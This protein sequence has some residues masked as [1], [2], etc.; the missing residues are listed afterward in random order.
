MRLY[1]KETLLIKTRGYIRL[2]YKRLVED[3][4]MK[5]FSNNIITKDRIRKILGENSGHRLKYRHDKQY[6]KNNDHVVR[7]DDNINDDDEV[8]VAV[9]VDDH[10]APAIK[11]KHEVQQQQQQQQRQRQQQAEDE[12]RENATALDEILKHNED[13]DEDRNRDHDDVLNEINQ[14]QTEDEA[15][16]NE[17][18]LE[19]MLNQEE[20]I[21]EDGEAGV[22]EEEEEEA[23][24]VVEEE[25]AV[26]VEEEAVVLN[27]A[28]EQQDDEANRNN[29]EKNVAILLL[30]LYHGTRQ[31]YQVTYNPYAMEASNL[32]FN[33]NPNI[34]SRM[35]QRGNVCQHSI[36]D[37]SSTSNLQSQDYYEILGVPKTA[38]EVII[39]K[40]YRKLAMQWHPDKNNTGAG[41]AD[42]ATRNFQIIS[43]AY[44]I[45]S[46]PQQRT[47]YD[48][49]G[50][51]AAESTDPMSSEEE[52]EE[53]D[54]EDDE[55]E[56][57]PYYR[58]FKRTASKLD[59]DK[60]SA[61]LRDFYCTFPE[62]R[63]PLQDHFHLLEE[64]NLNDLKYKF[65][66]SIIEALK[67]SSEFIKWIVP[68]IA[69][70][71]EERI[72]QEEENSFSRGLKREAQD[73]IM[74]VDDENDGYNTDNT[75][76]GDAA[77]AT[78]R[79]TKSQRHKRTARE[80]QNRKQIEELRELLVLGGVRMPT[81]TKSAV[82]T[83]TAQYIRRLQQ[84]P[85]QCGVVGTD[86][87]S[88]NK[89]R[90]ISGTTERRP[91]RFCEANIDNDNYPDNDDDDSIECIKAYDDVHN[92]S[93]NFDWV[94]NYSLPFAAID[95]LPVTSHPP[96]AGNDNKTYY[97]GIVSAEGFLSTKSELLVQGYIDYR[98]V[99]DH[100][101]MKK[102][103]VQSAISKWKR[104]VREKAVESGQTDLATVDYA[105][106]RPAEET[107]N[108]TDDEFLR[109][110]ELTIS[111]SSRTKRKRQNKRTTM[112]RKHVKKKRK[113]PPVVVPTT[114]SDTV[115]KG[116][117][118][119][120]NYQIRR[121][122]N[123]G[124]YYIG[125][126]VTSIAP[127]HTDDNVLVRTVAY[128]DGDVD[129]VDEKQLREWKYTTVNDDDHDDADSS[130]DDDD[131]VAEGNR[132]KAGAASIIDS[133]QDK[134]HTIRIDNRKKESKQTKIRHKSSRVRRRP[135]RFRDDDN[136][137]DKSNTI[138]HQ[139][140]SSR[141]RRRPKRF[142]DDDNIDDNY[143]VNKQK[144][145][146]QIP[147]FKLQSKFITQEKLLKKFTDT[148]IVKDCYLN[149]IQYIR[150]IDFCK[151]LFTIICPM[152]NDAKFNWQS[153]QPTRMMFGETK[154]RNNNH[155]NTVSRATY[156]EKQMRKAVGEHTHNRRCFPFDPAIV[157]FINHVLIPS[158]K[159]L[160]PSMLDMKFDYTHMELKMY[161]GTDVFCGKDQQ[162]L[163]LDG[164]PQ[165]EVIKTVNNNKC[166][167]HNDME[168]GL[169]GTQ[170][171]RDST[172]CNT[173][174]ATISLFSTRQYQY[175]WWRW[176]TRVD[177]P[178]WE[179]IPL[180]ASKLTLDHCSLNVL[181]SLDE[182]P[183]RKGDFYYKTKHRATFKVPN[184]SSTALIFRC[185]K[186]FEEYDR[187]TN[188]LVVSTKAG[189]KKSAG[190]KKR[191]GK[192]KGYVDK[193]RTKDVKIDTFRKS[194]AEVDVREVQQQ[195]QKNI[196]EIQNRNKFNG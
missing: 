45:L 148:T 183:F 60:V 134:S 91:L 177:E 97:L 28:H 9:I 136:I 129:I 64:M 32:I 109:V 110:A 122:W 3:K 118:E 154:N 106:G 192:K 121:L 172:D 180:S 17:A 65:Y 175:T 68:Y 195:I 139:K 21:N 120:I 86:A 62:L 14:D 43:E 141:K 34:T 92:E 4:I 58:Y 173:P 16:S 24:V 55:E 99:L 143:L 26:V 74:S 83:E 10:N 176:D 71:T 114:A 158:I 196:K 194:L 72:Q 144:E 102:I 89:K 33:P 87:A 127:R 88:T 11:V 81:G 166:N 146:N 80:I 49:Y 111:Q 156:A 37:I 100:V 31:C 66:V 179:M 186:T 76:E 132:K 167:H 78:F 46:D 151:D 130:H 138:R 98:Y 191:A 13:K 193:S 12:A 77:A 142:R 153:P 185:V 38:K 27:E 103:T 155:T 67:G 18:L 75:N 47:L 105:Y 112:T 164:S 149:L 163:E 25:A 44:A 70:I 19:E 53:E 48:Q 160:Y 52:E 57:E 152:N 188:L 7:T 113:N 1:R 108:M 96:V 170:D 116:N 162:P 40:A 181:H 190:I 41:N 29:D 61:C 51:D 79:P 73:P 182:T 184:G 54:E 115:A 5:Q 39:K 131:T 94:H 8:P 93:P 82:L 15:R 137:D 133:I 125:T 124:N 157:K 23:A 30:Q 42:G 20:E 135:K 161:N 6:P 168:F 174:I 35:I 178:K 171:P 104:Q 56:A 59:N 187:E 69:P 90:K 117:E 95:F 50:I 2:E 84:Q 189:K 150:G 126:V 128:A 147:N 101:V 36:T 165:K 140:N 107:E 123:D 169:D 119:Y 63:E 22:E 85:P 145:I 159:I